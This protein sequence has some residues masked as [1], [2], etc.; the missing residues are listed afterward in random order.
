M[1]DTLKDTITTVVDFA[2]TVKKDMLE[3]HRASADIDRE[4][5][6]ICCHC[7]EANSIYY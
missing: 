1:R 5:N 7:C 6:S 4:V 2:S 3:V